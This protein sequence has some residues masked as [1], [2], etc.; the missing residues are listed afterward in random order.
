VVVALEVED[1]EALGERIA[2]GG[3]HED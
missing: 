3:Y 2:E 1:E